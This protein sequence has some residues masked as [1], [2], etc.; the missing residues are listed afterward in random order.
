VLR[1]AFAFLTGIVF[2]FKQYQFEEN[3]F[4]DISRQRGKP[5]AALRQRIVSNSHWLLLG[6]IALDDED[7]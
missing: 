5:A 3:L 2:L 4:N 6:D 1:E 7:E